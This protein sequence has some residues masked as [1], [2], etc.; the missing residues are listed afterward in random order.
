M[1]TI[2]NTEKPQ[3]RL[4]DKQSGETIAWD[5]PG[6]PAVPLAAPAADRTPLRA[7][8][9]LAVGE[10]GVSVFATPAAKNLAPGHYMLQVQGFQDRAAPSPIEPVR[11]TTSQAQGAPD[12]DPLESALKLA[13][14][15]LAFHDFDQAEKI[16]ADYRAA[17]ARRATAPHASTEERPPVD[18]SGDPSCC[19]DNEGYGCHC[20]PLAAQPAAVPASKFDI[21]ADDKMQH[22]RDLMLEAAMSV[23]KGSHADKT[24]NAALD[25]LSDFQEAYMPVPVPAAA[26]GAPEQPGDY[27]QSVEV[28][29][30]ALQEITGRAQSALQARR[31]S[32]EMRMLFKQII[33]CCRAAFNE[34]LAASPLSTDAALA[35]PQPVGALVADLSEAELAF[36]EL[37]KANPG[38][39][40]SHND[41]F[42]AD[43]YPLWKKPEQLG[44]IE[45][46]GSYKWRALAT[47]TTQQG[48]E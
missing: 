42:D 23:G 37:V 45:C 25:L 6:A 12:L 18:C 5:K 2:D 8:A 36:V 19:P 28:L 3:R 40:L 30:N 41:A 34:S 13:L 32:G 14:G 35:A 38:K 22:V 48:G 31:S 29:L 44:L 20:T 21:T 24:L 47:P 1:D 10:D 46:L 16:G 26:P 4:E 39:K 27:S 17:E 11:D 15:S 33:N 7:V 9:S 43:S